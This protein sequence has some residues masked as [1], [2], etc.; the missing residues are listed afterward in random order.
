MEIKLPDHVWDTLA[1]PYCGNSLR[2][3][4]D[5]FKCT[6]CE[7]EYSS[8]QGIPDLRLKRKKTVTL[9]F[10]I[11]VNFLP[12]SSLIFS[13]LP[14]NRVSEVD[15]LK[16]RRPI[17][18]TRE[19]MSF[20]PKATSPDSIMLDLGCGNGIHKEICEDAGFKY[21]A[22]DYDDSDAPMLGDG[23]ALPFKDNSFDFIFSLAVLQ[24]IINPFVM[25]REAFRVLKPG[26]KIFGT[27]AFLEPF[28]VNSYYHHT[29]LGTFYTLKASGFEVE[30]VAPSVSWSVLKAQ[31][32]FLFNR[33]PAPLPKVIVMPVY[34]LHRLWWKAASF[35][36]N[37]A[38]EKKRVLYLTGSFTF[39]AKKPE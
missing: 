23:H 10:D 31:S 28:H 24:H 11:G 2:N 37:K 6:G 32:I 7:D 4:G 29:H 19:Q 20:L 14:R 27:V 9:Q 36:S 1:C 39:I 21:V 30:N 8:D 12:E 34:I 13:P 3:L 18:L 17:R 35:V 22:L 38:S 33:L 5:K 16:K 26:G 25:M 15:Y